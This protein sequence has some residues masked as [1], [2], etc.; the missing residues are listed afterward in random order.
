MPQTSPVSVTMIKRSLH[1][2]ALFKFRTPIRIGARSL[3]VSNEEPCLA[4]LLGYC[5]SWFVGILEDRFLTIH[6]VAAALSCP[7][8]FT[9]LFENTCVLRIASNHGD[10]Y[11]FSDAVE[12]CRKYNA[13][14]PSIHSFEVRTAS[15]FR[16]GMTAEARISLIFVSHQVSRSPEKSTGSGKLPRRQLLRVVLARPALLEQQRAARLHVVRRH[17]L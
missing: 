3:S 9:L 11:L 5:F 17:E 2:L 8:D 6:S 1:S 10:R 13:N 16:G 14:L 4:S 12:T 7:T 15:V